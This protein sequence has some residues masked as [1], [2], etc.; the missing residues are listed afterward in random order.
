VCTLNT[1]CETLD[2][3]VSHR[4][5]TGRATAVLFPT[6]LVILLLATVNPVKPFPGAISWL[7][8]VRG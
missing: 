5:S 6:V 7:P 4:K 2:F 1:C 8:N 3:A